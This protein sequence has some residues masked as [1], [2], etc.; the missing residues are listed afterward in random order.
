LDCRP[1]HIHN[2]LL[3]TLSRQTTDLD[4]FLICGFRQKPAGIR[5]VQSNRIDDLRGFDRYYSSWFY[6]ATHVLTMLPGGQTLES[7]TN[8]LH[9]SRDTVSQVVAFLRSAGL[10]EETNGRLYASSRRVHL[11]DDSLMIANH[12]TSWNLK[13]AASHAT[14]DPLDL[15][16]SGPIALSRPNA[17]KV[18]AMLL[19]FIRELD[20]ILAEPEEEAVYALSVDLFAL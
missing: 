16:Y 9:I 8:K 7:L 12:H 1:F 6:S 20:P 19:E 11:N 3:F 13:A 18:R 14:S 10:L 2:Y 17:Q 5:V 4:L 15:H